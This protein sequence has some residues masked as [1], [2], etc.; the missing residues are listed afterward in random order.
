MDTKDDGPCNSV[1]LNKEAITAEVEARVKVKQDSMSPVSKGRYRR[2]WAVLLERVNNGYC[3]LSVDG[4]LEHVEWVFTNKTPNCQNETMRLIKYVAKEFLDPHCLSPI[5]AHPFIVS[6]RFPAN[7]LLIMNLWFEQAVIATGVAPNTGEIHRIHQFLRVAI[8]VGLDDL[9]ELDFDQLVK[10]KDSMPTLWIKDSLPLF[11]NVLSENGGKRQLFAQ[12]WKITSV[13]Q[14]VV[15]WH[16][17]VELL[18]I[19]K[20]ISLDKVLANRE[21]VITEAAQMFLVGHHSATNGFNAIVLVMDYF[22]IPFTEQLVDCW[23]RDHKQ[24]SN[25][26]QIL[27]SINSRVRFGTSLSEHMQAARAPKYVV[28]KWI[29]LSLNEYLSKLSNY[30]LT[31]ESV[32]RQRGVLL[33]FCHFF[34]AEEFK[35]F[36]DLTAAAIEQ[37]NLDD[38]HKT[39]KAKSDANIIINKFMSF[40]AYKKLIPPELSH[41]LPTKISGYTDHRVVTLT[42][43]QYSTLLAYYRLSE[44]VPE[45]KLPLNYYRNKAMLLLMSHCGLRPS[46]VVTLRFSDFIKSN[47]GVFLLHKRQCKTGNFIDVAV[48]DQVLNAIRQYDKKERPKTEVSW[49]FVYM[50]DPTQHVYSELCNDVVHRVIGKNASPVMLRRTFATLIAKYPSLGLES[51]AEALGHRGIATVDHYVSSDTTMMKKCPLALEGTG[52]VGWFFDHE[53]GGRFNKSTVLGAAMHNIAVAATHK[54]GNDWAVKV[55]I[56]LEME[57]VLDNNGCKSFDDEAASVWLKHVETLPEIKKAARYLLTREL[58]LTLKSLG[59]RKLPRV[60]IPSGAQRKLHFESKL[61][62]SMMAFLENAPYNKDVLKTTRYALLKFD[63]FIASTTLDTGELSQSSF[64]AYISTLRENCGSSAIYATRRGLRDFAEY[65]ISHGVPAWVVP[66][67][68]RHFSPNSGRHTNH[69][70][71]T[72]QSKFGKWIEVLLQEK[73]SMGF[74]YKS[75]AQML[76][77]F[78][79]FVVG[80]YPDKNIV[81]KELGEAWGAKRQF[82]GNNARNNRVVVV[83][84]LVA[85]MH[86]YG[87]EGYKTP[88]I[89]FENKQIWYIPTES[90][91]KRFIE[92]IESPAMS[93]K[94]HSTD[95]RVLLVLVLFYALLGLRASEALFIKKEDLDLEE[96]T[97]ELK[98][99]KGGKSRRVWLSSSLITLTKSY[100]ASLER[101]GYK[102]DWL[103]PNHYDANHVD[104]STV[105]CFLND[106]WPAS[107]GNN[108]DGNTPTIVSFRHFFVINVFRVW[109][110]QGEN[111]DQLMKYLQE[112]LGHA[113]AQTT[114]DYYE[115]ISNV[116]PVVKAGLEKSIDQ[117]SD[118]EFHRNAEDLI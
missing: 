35:S 7:S 45:D 118:Y 17:P 93:P 24:Y 84:E 5:F 12:A 48:L 117:E 18:S 14:T 36:Q 33:R 29:E 25:S 51:A 59:E 69:T 19:E 90:A 62:S 53:L 79:C 49:L 23:V 78:D 72:Y 43:E 38:E 108:W 101:A 105:R 70:P 15:A 10:I 106:Y 103:F 22:D 31:P 21:A 60:T 61:G 44:L 99:T 16:P 52:C 11:L 13:V 26:R 89:K 109:S 65:Q 37:F 30:G 56:M 76:R 50:R 46:D 64:E 91:F 2:A 47:E 66:Q 27:L 32:A 63:N 85:L 83:N 77:S 55:S 68:N 97:V 57:Q 100:Q 6:E 86:R 111:V 80:K 1:S 113:K 96:G 4:L 94:R 87:M 40:L 3:Q 54:I 102:S 112:F 34:N 104:L 114:Y 116:L 107:Q 81:D 88:F 74:R 41:A 67:P 8:D 39:T 110:E 98:H 58:V 71:I 9:L 20:G 42:Q 115:Q 92:Y 75:Q 73:Q 82:E 95:L 28:P